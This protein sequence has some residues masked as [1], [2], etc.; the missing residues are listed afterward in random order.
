MSEQPGFGASV[1][2]VGDLNSDGFAD[3]A[4]G[5]PQPRGGTVSLFHGGDTINQAT[6]ILEA[7]ANSRRFGADIMGDIDRNGDGRADLLVTA[8][9]HVYQYS[10][11]EGQAGRLFQL[12]QVRGGSGS[13]QQVAMGGS[14]H[15]ATSFHVELIASSPYGR[16]RVKLQVEACP[17]AISAGPVSKQISCQLATSEHWIDTT[18][19]E[20]GIPVRLLVD[21]LQPDTAYQWRARLLYAPTTVVQEGIQTPL[22]PMHSPWYYPASSMSLPAIQTTPFVAVNTSSGATKVQNDEQCALY[23]AVLAANMNAPIGG[24]DAGHGIDTIGFDPQLQREILSGFHIRPDTPGLPPFTETVV[25]DGSLAP[26]AF[27]GEP[28]EL[29]VI[30]DGMESER[31]TNGL[32][33]TGGS[34]QSTVR[35]L[36]IGG[37]D[38]AGLLLEHVS[39]MTVVCNHLGTD[40]SGQQA[41]IGNRT[42]LHIVGGAN[43]TVGSD[44]EVG[45]NVIGGNHAG[46]IAEDVNNLVVQRNQIGTQASGQTPLG[47]AFVGVA[48]LGNGSSVV[49]GNNIRYQLGFGPLS[50]G[51]VAEGQVVAYANNITENG[52]AVDCERSAEARLEYN[53]WSRNVTAPMLADCGEAYAQ[54]LGAPVGAT[55]D[56]TN[57]GSW[58]ETG[59]PAIISADHL[60]AVIDARL[61]LVD[62]DGRGVLVNHGPETAQYV[63]FETAQPEVANDT[64]PCSNYYDFFSLDAT[65]STW[66]VR[67]PLKSIG[68]TGTLLK[69][70]LD[71]SAPEFPAGIC[72]DGDNICYWDSQTTGVVA[73]P[74]YLEQT[75]TSGERQADAI[76]LGA[77]VA[78]TSAGNDPSAITLLTF[79]ATPNQRSVNLLG[80]FESWL[81]VALLGA[82]ICGLFLLRRARAK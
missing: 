29:T 30:L 55:G 25:V 65:A 54:R 12:Q 8:I 61:D 37:F 64:Q 75:V 40:S 24:C 73:T 57:V 33:F 81:G 17:T 71:Q 67:V 13:R 19:T 80:Q 15:A 31:A 21:E 35:G 45:S 53:Y 2:G 34:D 4:V 6:Q 11:N 59:S 16:Q 48:L 5:A 22:A 74:F 10:N 60:G 50:L 46:I 42:G 20:Y 9:G 70:D 58:T 68:C 43:H 49:K 66:K 69:F 79:Q 39:G 7:P 51:L 52:T 78:D 27:C 28:R 72:T 1:A 76:G 41:N 82:A 38:G 18:A 32:T 56:A 36:T 44:D 26:K 47:N 63:P 62:G 77:Y 23:E 3:L 14:A